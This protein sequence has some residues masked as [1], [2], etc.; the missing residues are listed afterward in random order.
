MDK[1]PAQ[2]LGATRSTVFRSLL[3]SVLLTVVVVTSLGLSLERN[4]LGGTRVP[5]NA[6]QIVQQCQALDVLPGPPKDFHQRSESD[7]YVPGTPPTLLRNATLW[8]GRVSGHEVL[9]GDI[10]IDK[11]IIQD[12]GKIQDS[13]LK[14]YKDLV[15]VDAGGAWVTPGFVS[16]SMLNFHSSS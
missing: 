6:V 1:L 5:I 7:R 16:H 3:A 13:V 9:V 2:R 14:A 4:P 8:T 12:V 10:L 15:V 11:G